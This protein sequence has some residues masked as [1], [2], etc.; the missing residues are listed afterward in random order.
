MPI[1]NRVAAM[2]DEITAW[3]HDLHAHPEILYEVHR[4]AAFVADKLRGFGCD[5][6]VTGLG[7]TGVVGIIR[8]NKP[9]PGRTIA[10]RADMDA[11][12]IEEATDVPYKSKT[13]GAMHACG[14]DGHTAMLLGAAKYLAETRNFSGTAVMIFQPA[15][16]G[17]N[18]A[19]AMLDDGMMERFGVEAVYGMHNDPTLPIGAFGIR[20]GAQ[21]AAMDKFTIDIT[22]KGSHGAAPHLSNDPVIVVGQL[23]TSLQSIASRNADPLEAIVVSICVVEAGS[24]FNII[25]HTAKLIGTVRTL[26]EATRDLAEQRMRAIAAGLAQ[27]F[28]VDISVDY[29][30]GTPVLVNHADNTALAVSVAREVAGPDNVN[31]DVRPI[32]GGEDFAF[33]LNARPG[34]FIFVGNGPTAYCHHPAYDFSDAA[35][36]YGVSYWVKMI[37]T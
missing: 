3:R 5:E 8:G 27:S 24:A 12:P 25:P 23:I 16:E 13:P 17:G 7:R 11:L 36:P 9:G 28:S 15:E 31:P 18:G 4:T 29:W 35:I 14:H 33:M 19:L 6:V 26:S 1:L 22:G 2:T 20:T 21:L 37:E 34:A 30:R 32:M 10:L